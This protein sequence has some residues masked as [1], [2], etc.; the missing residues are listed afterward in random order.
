MNLDPGRFTFISLTTAF[1]QAS[2]FSLQEYVIPLSINENTENHQEK[3]VYY[4]KLGVSSGS[5]VSITPLRTTTSIELGSKNN[6]VRKDKQ[7][8]EYKG[9]V[10]ARKCKGVIIKE[11]EVAQIHVFPG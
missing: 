7:I 11:R 4:M 3:G 10:T 6:G 2:R 1:N 8:I 5:R 9:R